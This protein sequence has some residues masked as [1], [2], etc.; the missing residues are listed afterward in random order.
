MLL[1]VSSHLGGAAMD[2][3]LSTDEGNSNKHI[4]QLISALKRTDGETKALLTQILAKRE[5]LIPQFFAE[6][7]KNNINDFG[8]TQKTAVKMDRQG[9]I[10][11]KRFSGSAQRIAKAIVKVAFAGL[12][13]T[14]VE[15]LCQNGTEKFGNVI[16][17]VSVFKFRAFTFL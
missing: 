11:R 17:W 9:E 4:F 13:K 16:K 1:K 10:R 7:T 12:S 6:V 14:E 15:K 3:D 8:L 5:E 2:C